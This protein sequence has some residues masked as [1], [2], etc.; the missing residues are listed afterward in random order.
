MLC[1]EICLSAG[2]LER[3]DSRKEVDVSLEVV[4]ERVL[5]E[6]ARVFFE[7]A[8]IFSTGPKLRRAGRAPYLHMLNWLAQQ[9]EWS[10]QL[11]QALSQH[12]E[13]RGSVGQVVD[14]GFLKSFMD[15]K[16]EL[17]DIIHYD[18]ITRTLSVEDPK[19]IYFL[20][21]IIWNKF[22]KQ[23]GYLANS[24]AGRYDFA[25][26]FAG[27]DRDIASS[28][29]DSL[30]TAEVEVFY[31]QNE[32]HRILASNVEDYLAPIYR[33]EA[34]YVVVLLGKEYPKRIWTKF[35][36]EQF[37]ARFGEKSVIPIWFTDAPAG[38]FDETTRVGGFSI[39][40]SLDVPYQVQALTELLLKKLTESRVELET[41]EEIVEPSDA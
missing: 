26:S 3:E 16:P 31:D 2:I 14:K 39:D 23:V 34:A 19:F 10:M 25:L 5:D 8:R 9:D 38:M 30:T 35:E 40:R 32:Q 29:F 36:S 24:F 22:S 17:A 18:D 21:N 33:T 37:K 12:Q 13:H 15:A 7:P 27:A 28:L 6:L 4:R 11:D 41:V 1:R 20:R